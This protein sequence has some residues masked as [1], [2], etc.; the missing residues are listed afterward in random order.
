MTRIGHQGSE[1]GL[2]MILLFTRPRTRRE[3]TWRGM[4][5]IVIAIRVCQ[6]YIPMHLMSPTND[7]ACT[8]VVLWSI[9]RARVPTSQARILSQPLHK[10]IR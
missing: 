6:I 3:N 7:L 8:V 2:S 1:T 10:A 9:L 4:C 5:F